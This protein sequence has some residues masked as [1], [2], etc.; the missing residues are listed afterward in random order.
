[1][2]GPFAGGPFA[3]KPFKRRAVGGGGDAGAAFDG[4]FVARKSANQAVNLN[5]GNIYELDISFGSG[6]ATLSGNQITINETG[7]YYLAWTQRGQVNEGRF[8]MEVFT[9]GGAQV[10]DKA[11]IPIR[12]VGIDNDITDNSEGAQIASVVSFTAG[13]VIQ[14]QIVVD[15]NITRLDAAWSTF[16]LLKVA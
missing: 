3:G 15:Q 1:M 8:D 6:I 7:D 5:V 4:Y 13:D 9:S 14:L 11:G 2:Q 10:L 12:V 16:M